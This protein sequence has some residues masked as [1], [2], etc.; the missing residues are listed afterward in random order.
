MKKK[1]RFI[2]NPRSGMNSKADL[3]SLIRLHLDHD[4]FAAEFRFTEHAGHAT[5]LSQEG[6]EQGCDIIAI[7]GG[8]GS[9]NEAAAPLRHSQTALALLPCGSGNG[10]A[11]HLGIPMDL[12]A[13]VRLIGSGDVRSIDTFTAGTH[14]GV[15]TFGIGFDAHVAHLFAKSP[16]RGYGTYVRLVLGQFSSYPAF[17]LSMEVD[18]QTVRD[19]LFL[20]TF[21]NSSQFGNNAVIAPGADISD[22]WIDLAMV[23]PFPWYSAPR[24]IYLLSTNALNRSRFYRRIKGKRIR[25]NNPGELRAHIDGE[26]VLMKGDFHV[27]L[28]S[29]SL[30][31]I[32][33]SDRSVGSQ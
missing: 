24:L 16:K 23:R 28:E 25:V 5:I 2:I 19:R 29:R 32:V 11:R 6:K 30:K 14:Q 21:A 33:P 4:R 22:G 10:L 15:G 31:I 1:I 8:D 3:P 20:M 27:E 7:A 17:D 9:M 18:G 12:P 13:A 26:P